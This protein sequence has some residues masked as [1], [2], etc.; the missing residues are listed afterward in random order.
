M[1]KKL[2]PNLVKIH[3][4]YLVEEIAGLFAVHKNTVRNWIKNGLPVVD[5]KRPALIIGWA[6]KDYLQ[7]RRLKCKRKCRPYE[8]YCLSCRKPQTPAEGM[9]EY[10]PSTNTKG[11][12]VG[13]CPDCESWINK[14]STLAGAQLLKGKLDVTLPM[15]PERVGKTSQPLLNSDFNR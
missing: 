14:Y 7:A 15:V 8:L 11:R 12:L 9:V 2:N 5:D 1:P 4:S 6:L 3:R 10:I 13:I